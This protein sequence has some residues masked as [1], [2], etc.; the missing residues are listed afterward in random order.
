MDL[1]ICILF[2]FLCIFS[3]SGRVFASLLFKDPVKMALIG[4]TSEVCNLC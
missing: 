1:T 4:K 3:M 2:T